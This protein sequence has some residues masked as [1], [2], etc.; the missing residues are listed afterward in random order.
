MSINR[1]LEAQIKVKTTDTKS[2][3]DDGS[4]NTWLVREDWQESIHTEWFH[5]YEVLE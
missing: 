4:Q 1:R 5:L 3:I 2:N